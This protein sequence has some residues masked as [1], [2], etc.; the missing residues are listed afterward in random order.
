MPDQSSFNPAG[1]WGG[2]IANG[3]GNGI[4]KLTILG[5][6]EGGTVDFIVR[7][8]NE[9]GRTGTTL[10]EVRKGPGNNDLSGGV[11][12]ANNPDYADGGQTTLVTFSGKGLDAPL[13]VRV[14]LPP[15]AEGGTFR[16]QAHPG[17]TV[18]QGNGPGVVVFLACGQT[19]PPTCYDY[20]G[21]PV[22]CPTAAI[23][24]S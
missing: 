12:L 9:S 16:I 13:Y 21:N 10:F 15:C 17:G 8:N 22:V 11:T 6:A 18:H 2:D 5:T 19:P 4:N 23:R 14:S 3:G 20:N 7:N 1:A 24:E